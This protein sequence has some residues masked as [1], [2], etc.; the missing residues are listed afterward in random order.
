MDPI[1]AGAY[2]FIYSTRDAFED[3]I[4]CIEI[5]REGSNCLQDT[6]QYLVCALHLCVV[7]HKSE[8]MSFRS[9]N[10]EALERLKLWKYV[11]VNGPTYENKEESW[12][13]AEGTE[14]S[15]CPLALRKFAENPFAKRQFTKISIPCKPIQWK[16]FF[17]NIDWPN[18]L[19]TS[20]NYFKS[21]M[22]QFAA[23]VS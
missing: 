5:K 17:Q 14:E 3:R 12:E 15:S 6:S 16:Q 4:L 7:T 19:N 22:R 10:L 2:F 11:T 18:S 23:T 8:S 1:S 13:E 21:D 9:Q 20:N